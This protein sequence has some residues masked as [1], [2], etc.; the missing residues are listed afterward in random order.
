MDAGGGAGGGSATGAAAAFGVVAGA[1]ASSGASLAGTTS[2]RICSGRSWLR[3]VLACK[4][5]DKPG[6]DSRFAN[7]SS[8]CVGC[9][10][11]EVE[12]AVKEFSEGRRGHI[13]AINPGVHGWHHLVEIDVNRWICPELLQN[14]R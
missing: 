3:T 13:D 7:A 12:L 5:G 9:A 10:E 14:G 2:L 11:E 8:T 4:A 6:R 1:A